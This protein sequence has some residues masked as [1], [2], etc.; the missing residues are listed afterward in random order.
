MISQPF[1]VAF[2]GSVVILEGSLRK[3]VLNVISELDDVWVI[4]VR[5]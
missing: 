3:T 4:G 1:G 2:N 5:L